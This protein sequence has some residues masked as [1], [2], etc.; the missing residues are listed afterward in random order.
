VSI[1][2]IVRILLACFLGG[3]IGIERESLRRPAGFRTHM[4]VCMGSALIM[5]TGEYVFLNYQ[6]LTNMDP[7]RLGAQVVS[8]IGFLGA[9]T[10]IKEGGTVR[11]LTTAASLW[12]V[13]C[14]GLAVGAGF[15]WV[16]IAA[17]AVIYIILVV[18]KYIEQIMAEKQPRTQVVLYFHNKPGQIGKIGQVLGQ[19]NVLILNIKLDSSEEGWTRSQWDLKLPFGLN[20]EVLL[21]E[22]AQLEGVEEDLPQ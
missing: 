15:Y 7:T 14:V 1:V 18:L 10:I 6:H 3:L 19:L 5:V 11:G 4:L 2:Y 9:G 20:K 13:S 21:A 17:S 8:G 12:A 16:G 22:L